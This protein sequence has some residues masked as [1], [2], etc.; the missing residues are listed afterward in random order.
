M[1]KPLLFRFL[2]GILILFLSVPSLP[3]IAVNPTLGT[4]RQLEEVPGQMVYQS[5]QNL[6]DT[7]G[8]VWIAIAFKRPDDL[9]YLRL[10]G[11]PGVVEIDRTQPL[12]LIDSLN[13]TQLA[14][15]ASAQM[16]IEGV[17]PH[18]GQYDLQPLV[19]ELKPEI[20]L[21]LELPTVQGTTVILKLP[22]SF[23]QDW[24][25]IASLPD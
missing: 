8:N 16:F 7:Q 9:L 17:Q 6:R 4:I 23:V 11:F 20:P 3:A 22:P 10:V 19:S 25:A 18:I 13:H 21:H 2:L 24:I 12:R 1:N 5:R 14:S 15:D